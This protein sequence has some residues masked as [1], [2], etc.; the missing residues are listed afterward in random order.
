M[1]S[2]DSE[3]WDLIFCRNVIMYLS[4]E[5]S[6]QV[7]SRLERALVPGGYLFL[8]H[9]ETLLRV[10]RPRRSSYAAP[11]VRSITGAAV[12]RA[13]PP[14]TRRGSRTSRPR[15]GAPTHSSRARSRPADHADRADH[16]ELADHAALAEEAPVAIATLIAEERYAEATARLADLPHRSRRAARPG[17]SA[18]S[19]MPTPARRAS[20]R[21]HATS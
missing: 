12:R 20:P 21:P 16:A 15:P 4:E 3:R 17:C 5:R 19:S 6:R 10:R 9:A 7:V 8:G 14:A 18:R 11:T 2:V 1:A 13:R